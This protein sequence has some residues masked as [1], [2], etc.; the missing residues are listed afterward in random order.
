MKPSVHTLFKRIIRKIQVKSLLNKLEYDGRGLPEE[1][2]N[3]FYLIDS[4]IDILEVHQEEDKL[5]EYLVNT[6]LYIPFLYYLYEACI[7]MNLV[8]I[9]EIQ[10]NMKYIFE[11]ARI[12]QRNHYKSIRNNL[13]FYLICILIICL[14]VLLYKISLYSY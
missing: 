4:S 3:L 5:I 6:P 8:T 12:N 9:Q 13:Q 10:D 7:D 14:F 2:L 11:I 1:F